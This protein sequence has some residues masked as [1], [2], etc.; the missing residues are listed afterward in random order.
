MLIMKSKEWII[1]VKLELIYSKKEILT[2]YAN[3]V[4]FGNNSYGVKTAAKTYF[5]TTPSKMSVDQAATLVGM[6]KATTY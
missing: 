6:L 4:D 3:T 1:A 2:M 5:N